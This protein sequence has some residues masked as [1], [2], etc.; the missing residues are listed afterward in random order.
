MLKNMSINLKRT[1]EIVLIIGI[2]IVGFMQYYEKKKY[3]KYISNKIAE[4]TISDFAYAVLFT[5]DILKEIL[6]KNVITENQIHNLTNNYIKIIEYM[7][8][9]RQIAGYLGVTIKS[10][11]IISQFVSNTC[12]YF[13]S[14][15]QVK[16]L[17]GND[18]L[19]LKQ[20]KEIN[21]EWLKILEKNIEE[22]PTEGADVTIR[23]KYESKG[24]RHK[25]WQNIYNEFM[26][27]SCM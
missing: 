22:I 13:D 14:G 1:I 17:D 27:V 20:I 16:T 7:E 21:D 9:I 4:Y 3:E 8:G 12:Y 10:N 26:S 23:N 24:V 15:I 18:R 11:D 25:Y 5:N 19:K 6:S 2:C